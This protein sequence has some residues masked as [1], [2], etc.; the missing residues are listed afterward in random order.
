MKKLI[1]LIISLFVFTGI[2]L[3]QKV[4]VKDTSSNVL[5]EINDEGK[6]GSITIPD[7][8]DAPAA[9][10]NK[11]YNI[12]GSLYWNGSTLGSSGSAGGWTDDGTTIRLSTSTDKVGIGTTSPQVKLSLGTDINPKK[13]ALWDGVGDFYGLGCHIGRITFF[14]NNTE[15]M[16]IKD[17]GN[18]GIGTT[19]PDT[20]L[21]VEGT[22]DLMTLAKI[23]Q[24]GNKNYAGLR[25]DRENAEKWFIGMNH[26]DDKLIFRRNASSNDVTISNTG[27]LGVGTNNPSQL[28]HIY[29][30]SNPRLVVE[31]PGG[32]TPEFN[33]KRGTET[34]SLFMNSSNSL[35]FYKS[36]TKVTF[37]SAG[38]VG[39]GTI[40]PSQKLDIDYGNIIVQGTNSFTASGHE[41]VV[42]LGSVH[43]FIKGIYGTGIKIGTYAVA[44][45]ITIK[46]LS[47]NVGIGTTTPGQRLTVRGNILVEN[48][49]GVAVLELGEGLDYA[50]GFDVTEK[51]EIEPGTVLIIDPENPGKLSVSNSPYDSKVAGIV[52]GA[53]GLGSGVRIGSNEFDF[54]V[55]LAGRVYCNVDA[56]YSAVEPGDLLTTSTTA[57]HA[58]KVTDYAKANGAILGKAMDELHKGE[59]G[60]ILVLVTLQ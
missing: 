53:N 7:T 28:L 1:P 58:M 11:L 16:T 17:N 41:G 42:Y 4:T 45:A 44:D 57:G 43:H 59:K 49:S 13:F 29:G 21:T 40:S 60:Q 38:N 50:E 48:T 35:S 14:T 56:S 19:N 36:G 47:G 3:A 46:E 10:T 6:V 23:N 51:K 20:K 34:Y 5:L 15:K 52:A 37:S 12:G 2:A 9:T 22:A 27:F 18:V 8:T 32:A 55:A 26:V 54:D 24:V 25:I 33:L 39:I 30:L 31:A